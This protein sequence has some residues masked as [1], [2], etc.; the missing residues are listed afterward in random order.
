MGLSSHSAYAMINPFHPV[1]VMPSLSFF[2]MNHSAK[3]RFP[4]AAA[5]RI[6]G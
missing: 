4:L 6:K 3:T 5:F 2:S 1:N